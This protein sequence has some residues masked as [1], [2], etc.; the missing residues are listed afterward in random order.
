MRYC[1][2]ALFTVGANSLAAKEF[3]RIIALDL[4]FHVH[5]HVIYSSDLRFNYSYITNIMW[6]L[7]R[8]DPAATEGFC[9]S[10]RKLM[11]RFMPRELRT[12]YYVPNLPKN[13]CP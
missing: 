10:M 2:A 1:Y 13:D 9:S 7:T 11:V 4:K 12:E 3:Q 5:D 8:L 6:L